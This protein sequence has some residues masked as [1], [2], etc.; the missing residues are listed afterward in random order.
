MTENKD[1]KKLAACD[2][3]STADWWPV[4]SLFET[5]C[6]DGLNEAHCNAG[7]FHLF[8]VMR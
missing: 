8:T 7:L 5:L 1:V 6:L 3:E 4:R 2:F